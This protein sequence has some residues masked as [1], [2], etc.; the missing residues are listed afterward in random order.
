MSLPKKAVLVG[1]NYF[2]IPGIT[3]H[4]CI[5]DVVNM[6]HTLA[7]AFDYDINNIT[8]LRDDTQNANLYPTRNN[9]LTQLVNVVNQSAN[10][11]EIWFHYSGHGSQ[12]R[13]INMDEADGLD[14]VIVPVDYQRNGFIIDDEIFNIIKNVKCRMIMLFDSCHNGS[15]CDLK[16][17]FEYNNGTII[18]SINSGKLATNPNIFVFSGCKDAQTSADAY[19]VQ[20]QQ[21]VGAF[22]DCF[23]YCLRLNHMNVDIM[24]LYN[25]IC[26]YIKSNGFTQ[27]PTLTSSSETPSFNFVRATSSPVANTKTIISSSSVLSNTL[28]DIVF[29]E[30]S[31]MFPPV[32]Y[33]DFL[34]NSFSSN[35]IKPPM[36][37]LLF[38]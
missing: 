15:I 17:G 18:K 26:L 5:N 2:S 27:T 13:D 31:N 29:N 35:R 20:A 19:S 37:K 32:V 21:S 38:L 22:T 11:S 3:L 4:G 23:L 36:G 24:K 8:I 9:I 25:D 14:E 34:L 7:D 10:L 6:S 28:K 16:W 1:I 30:S 12:V 33:S